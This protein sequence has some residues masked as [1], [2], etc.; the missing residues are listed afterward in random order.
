MSIKIILMD[1]GRNF[2]SI[3]AAKT[4]IPKPKDSTLK[5]V[6]ITPG[7]FAPIKNGSIYLLPTPLNEMQS[8]L[9]MC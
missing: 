8:L 1:I 4:P 7:K 9:L 3:K 6:I 2:H 5:S